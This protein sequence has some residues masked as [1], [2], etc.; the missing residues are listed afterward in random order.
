MFF[1]SAFRPKQKVAQN[2]HEGH[3]AGYHPNLADLFR[4]RQMEK[5]LQQTADELK[6]V[7]TRLSRLEEALA[8]CSDLEVAACGE[9]RQAACD[10]AKQSSPG[11]STPPLPIA[12]LKQL[13]EMAKR[14]R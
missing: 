12:E 2:K 3:S 5:M 4:L 6:Q 9:P 10:D 1:L 14:F 7:K 11:P 8:G 13:A